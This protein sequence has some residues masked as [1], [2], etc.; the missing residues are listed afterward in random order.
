MPKASKCVGT[1]FAI[2]PSW[3]DFLFGK[4][5]EKAKV[6]SLGEF[7]RGGKL[8]A[9]KL[10]HDFCKTPWGGRQAQQQKCLF[11]T[12]FRTLFYLVKQGILM[13]IHDTPL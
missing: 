3:H 13:S 12:F 4:F 6:F 1:D 11:L 8:C 5:C 9:K 10:W 2:L 7:R